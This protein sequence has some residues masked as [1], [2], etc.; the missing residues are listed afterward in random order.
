M[1]WSDIGALVLQL[2]AGAAIWA[3][4]LTVV[5]LLAG[6]RPTGDPQIRPRSGS[7]DEPTDELSP[8][9]TVIEASALAVSRGWQSYD[10]HAEL[11]EDALRI[12]DEHPSI[13]I[14][15]LLARLDPAFNMTT[16]HNKE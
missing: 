2:L 7:D 12:T 6:P 3:A 16:N 9:D 1:T 4:V 15:G 10:D 11:V 8:V 14:P 5:N 13:G